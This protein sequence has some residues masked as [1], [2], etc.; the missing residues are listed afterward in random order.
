M[1]PSLDMDITPK[2]FKKIAMI[3]LSNN[4]KPLKTKQINI[5]KKFGFNTFVSVG[6]ILFSSTTTVSPHY[7]IFRPNIFGGPI[8]I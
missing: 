2:E 6:A 7:C 1:I 3:S 4:N 8:P 5:N